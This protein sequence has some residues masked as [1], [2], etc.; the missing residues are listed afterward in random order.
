MSPTSDRSV[1][2]S[3]CNHQKDI[4]PVYQYMSRFRATRVKKLP[5]Q[6]EMTVLDVSRCGFFFGKFCFVKK[7][8]L[9]EKTAFLKISTKRGSSLT[10]A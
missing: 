1:I 3:L 10:L 4:I 6:L 2:E 7:I 9:A 8:F 5:A